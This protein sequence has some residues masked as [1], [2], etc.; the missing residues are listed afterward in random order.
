MSRRRNTRPAAAH[1]AQLFAD[2]GNNWKVGDAVASATSGLDVPNTTIT[3]IIE[4]PGRKIVEMA[5]GS[6]C[7]I[8]N[9]RRPRSTR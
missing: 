7:H 1:L 4:Q 9:V 5:D 3:A 2:A 6:A 8:S